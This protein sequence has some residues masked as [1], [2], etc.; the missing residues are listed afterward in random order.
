MADEPLGAVPVAQSSAQARKK[1]YAYSRWQRRWT[2]RRPW[3]PSIRAIRAV[4]A[5]RLR[6]CSNIS[7]E[8]T[9]SKASLEDELVNAPS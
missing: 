3:I 6:M 4:D 8:T 7:T 2:N 1:T 9:R 5:S